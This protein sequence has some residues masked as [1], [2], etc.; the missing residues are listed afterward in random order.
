MRSCLDDVLG[1][2][3][4]G[5]YKLDFWKCQPM[6]FCVAIRVIRRQHSTLEYLFDT[7]LVPAWY[8]ENK[9]GEQPKPLP[10]TWLANFPPNALRNEANDIGDNA[11]NNTHKQSFKCHRSPPFRTKI[12][13]SSLQPTNL[14][15]GMVRS[16]LRICEL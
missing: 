2:Q 5:Y 16:L 11:T 13:R 9:N 15:L 3:V 6:P 7:M 4:T 1:R 14:G 8:L 10:Y 12:F